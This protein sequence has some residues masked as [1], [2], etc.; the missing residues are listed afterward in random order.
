MERKNIYYA[1]AYCS[2]QRSTNENKNDTPMVPKGTDFT[3]ITNAQIQEVNDWINKYPRKQFGYRTS[4]ELFMEQYNNTC[5]IV[6]KTTT[7][8]VIDS[9]II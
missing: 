4:N 9:Y 8:I 6:N 1:H 3:T 7:V 5:C 2:W